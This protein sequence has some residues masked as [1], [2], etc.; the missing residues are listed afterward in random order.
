MEFWLIPALAMLV[1]G[2]GIFYMVIRL[3]GG[4]GA[5]NDGQTMLDKP[6]DEPDR[7][8]AGWNYYK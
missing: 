2:V 7:Q 3:H 8:R 1:A 5:R 6:A 4:T